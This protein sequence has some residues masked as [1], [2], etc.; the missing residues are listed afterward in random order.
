VA[1]WCW[2][3]N[4]SAGSSGEFHCNQVKVD[5]G[6]EGGWWSYCS[7]LL[8]GRSRVERRLNYGLVPDI[9]RVFEGDGYWVN[10]G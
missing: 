2:V 6:R 10:K 1:V 3:V 8:L 5:D 9:L 4:G 7:G